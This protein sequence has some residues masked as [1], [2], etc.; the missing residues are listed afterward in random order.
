MVQDAHTHFFSRRFFATLAEVAAAKES[1][2]T[3]TSSAILR[4]ASDL[5]DKLVQKTGLEIPDDGDAHSKRWLAELD[6]H[7]VTRAVTFASVPPEGDTVLE[8]AA[9]SGG[10]LLPYV[11]C[12]P[13]QENGVVAA[14]HEL[15]QG[16]RG[17]LLFPAVGHFDVSA[18]CFDKLY[19]EAAARAAPVVV[20]CGVLQVKVRDVLGIRPLYDLRYASPLAVSF[21][22][23]RH[24]NVTFVIPHFG[25][26]FFRETLLAGAQSSNICVDTSSSNSWMAAQGSALT[27]DHVFAQALDIF[28][29]ERI[30]FGTDSCT[31]PRGWR[32]DLLDEQL[33]TLER[34]GVEDAAQ[35]RILGENLAELLP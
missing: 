29:P 30:L 3:A 17:V 24:P 2:P 4:R 5:L 14:V 13:T 7:G 35:E 11:F 15:R 16:G 28:G 10:R 31:F 26:G 12:D 33:A 20:H 27:L 8:A 9:Q 1:G 32:S 22:A 18:E 23:E 21:A 6:R 19:E 25:G 34:L